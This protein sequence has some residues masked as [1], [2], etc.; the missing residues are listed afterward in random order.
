MAS[1]VSNAPIM[2]DGSDIAPICFRKKKSVRRN[3]RR[4]QTGASPRA[5]IIFLPN[6]LYH[7]AAEMNRLSGMF[8]QKGRSPLLALVKGIIL[9][10]TL[11]PF[12]LSRKR[13]AEKSNLKFTRAKKCI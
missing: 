6:I 3:Q 10:N 4:T 1:T 9:R 13:D 8:F 11:A 7:G 12:P 2:S 5:N